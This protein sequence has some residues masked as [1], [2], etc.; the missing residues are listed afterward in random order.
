MAI[1]DMI[2]GTERLALRHF[3]TDDLDCVARY[4]TLPE[5]QRYLEAPARDRADCKRALETMMRHVSLQRPGD[6]LSFAI[7]E[8]D[9]GALAGHVSLLWADATAAQGEMRIVIDPQFRRHG[10][11]REAARAVIDMGFAAHGFHRIFARCDGRNQAAA[12]LLKGLGMRLEA[13]YREH[14]LFQG[15]WDEELHFAVLDREWRR[16]GNVKELSRLVA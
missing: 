16:P 10:Y 5:L 14:A 13:H 3:E 9:G 2:I 15:E 1:Q 8:R 11:A 4:L 7:T 12:R 6:R